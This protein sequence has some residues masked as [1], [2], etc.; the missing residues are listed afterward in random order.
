M[1]ENIIE[2]AN[3]DELPP[4]PETNK[5]TIADDKEVVPLK[6]KELTEPTTTSLGGVSFPLSDILAKNKQ[7]KAD[8]GIT[9]PKQTLPTPPKSSDYAFGKPPQLTF[10]NKAKEKQL[11]FVS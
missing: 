3:E 1:A 9:E 5:V 8:L 7:V 6:K 4:A 10:D 11:I 2:I